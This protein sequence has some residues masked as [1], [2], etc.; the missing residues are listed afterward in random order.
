M[1]LT[2]ERFEFN[3][4]KEAGRA[5]AN[6]K[7]GATTRGA[8]ELYPD[9]QKDGILSLDIRGPAGAYRGSALI[10]KATAQRVGRALLEWGIIDASQ[11]CDECADEKGWPHP[12]TK[13]A[14]GICPLCNEGERELNVAH[15][16]IP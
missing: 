4:R 11:Y 7:N 3:T 10:D 5:N 13:R 2:M 1:E 6:L 16:V 12:L 14:Y 8:I 9:F 15:M